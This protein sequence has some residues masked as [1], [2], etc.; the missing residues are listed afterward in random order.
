MES[1]KFRKKFRV[2]FGVRN[3]EKNVIIGRIESFRENIKKRKL[4]EIIL[5]AF[6]SKRK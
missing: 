3:N 2:F 6:S 1:L 5:H 4:L